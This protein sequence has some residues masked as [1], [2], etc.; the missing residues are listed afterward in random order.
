M[1]STDTGGRLMKRCRRRHGL[2]AWRASVMLFGLRFDFRN[3]SSPARQWPTAMPP[4]WTSRNGPTRLG[5][6]NIA[7]SEHHGSPDGYLPSPIPM[8][9][10]MAARTTNV[11]FI[12]AAL[13]APF[14]DPLRLAEDLIVLDN[15]SR[16]RVDFIVAGGYVHEEFAMFGV[17]MNERGRAGHRDRRHARP[18]SPASRSSTGVARCTSRRHRSGRAAHRSCSAAAASRPPDRAARIGDGFMPTVPEVWE[19]YR[20]EVQKLGRPDPGPEPDRRESRS[21]RWPRI[22]S[23]AGRRWRPTSSTRPTPMARGRHRTTSRPRTTPSTAS[24]SCT[25]KAST[26]C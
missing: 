6:V 21:S 15:L 25:P 22:L 23:R 1:D 8:V 11:R 13:I 5:C 4:P 16:G 20:D 18:R 17:P 14:Y 19:F 24:I 7:V 12:I 10:A 2:W 3:P 9:A 26:A